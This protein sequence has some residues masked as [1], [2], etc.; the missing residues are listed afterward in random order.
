MQPA[1]PL[2]KPLLR[3]GSDL[4]ASVAEQAIAPCVR[5]ADVS[6]LVTR[7]ATV[8][9]LPAAAFG[10]RRLATLSVNGCAVAGGEAA[11]GVDAA[12]PLTATF[13][14]GA[15]ICGQT[16]WTLKVPPP[17]TGYGAAV[18]N[19]HVAVPPGGIR[20]GWPAF[21]LLKARNPF[22]T[23]PRNSKE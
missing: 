21:A 17:L 8:N 16:D 2:L 1:R 19:C 20:P 12:G 10:T 11:T 9:G 5:E 22:E 7:I 23:V 4:P 18:V 15:P 13:E 6:L 3:T 14:V